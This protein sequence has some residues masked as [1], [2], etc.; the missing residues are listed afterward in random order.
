M[1]LRHYVMPSLYVGIA[2]LA[3][4]ESQK[5]VVSIVHS[6]KELEEAYSNISTIKH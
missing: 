6:D 3:T 4:L 1:I 2:C 5:S